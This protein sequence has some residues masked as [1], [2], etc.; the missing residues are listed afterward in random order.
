IGVQRQLETARDIQ[1]SLLPGRIPMPRGL[2][3]AVRY[4]PAAAV[5][6]DIY[7]FVE[8]GPSCI[9]ILVADVMGH[10]IPAALV[11]SMAKLAFSLQIERAHDPSAVLTSMN[12][13]L[14]GQLQGSYVT[15]VYA[16]VDTN[17]GR[18]TLAHAGHPPPL[19]PP[20]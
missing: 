20:R 5:A 8:I 1:R 15:A 18:V 9:G 10:G 11:A 12:Q 4:V 7:D 14:C 16:V 6:G 17:A 13:I 3:V 2:D 19:R